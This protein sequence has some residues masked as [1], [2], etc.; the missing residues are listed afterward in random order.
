MELHDLIVSEFERTK[1]VAA[2]IYLIDHG[3]ELE[4]S[5][6]GKT[7][8]ISHDKS[9]KYVSLWEGKDEQSFDSM[10]ALIETSVISNS[11]FLSALPEI[12]I[13]TIF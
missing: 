1:S 4:F 9:Q 3:R 8:F 6:E 7:Y 2:L 12:K 5:F 13:D 11:A 10:E